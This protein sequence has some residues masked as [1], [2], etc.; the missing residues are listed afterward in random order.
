MDCKSFDK[1]SSLYIDDVLSKEEAIEYENHLKHCEKC[2]AAH[3]NL[4][5]IVTC[6][7]QMQEIDLPSS[8]N[9]TLREKLRLQANKTEYSPKKKWLNLRLVKGIAA[10][11]LV[12]LVTATTYS[13]FMPNQFRG[14]SMLM[15]DEA[16]TEANYAAESEQFIDDKVIINE[17]VAFNAN[18]QMSTMATAEN[19]SEF[20]LIHT[21]N[22]IIETT[23][24]DRVYNSVLQLVNENN[25]YIQQSESFYRHLN[26]ENPKDSLRYANIT[27]RIPS[28][29][30]KGVFNEIESL[31]RVISRNTHTENITETYRDTETQVKNLE[32][33]EERLQEILR[34]ADKVE[35][36]LKIENELSRIRLEINRYK[37]TLKSYDRLVEMSTIHLEIN[38]VKPSILKIQTVD[39]GIWGKAKNNFIQSVNAIIM[40]GQKSFV[41]LFGLLPH[42][43]IISALIVPLGWYL[44]K[45]YKKG[46]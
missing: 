21:G 36:L 4:K 24:F 9:N 11:V 26:K 28:G 8:F 6:V 37:G 45:K 40:T 27:V 43:L 14:K 12:L 16:P 33:Q 31:D 19:F 39:E 20:K 42:L 25:G 3:K 18:D 5:T 38:E 2:N 30:F 15:T 32:I 23:D 1:F 22:I 10:G 13:S 46:R 44:L 34:K 29:T 17:D 35:D 7:N 41:S